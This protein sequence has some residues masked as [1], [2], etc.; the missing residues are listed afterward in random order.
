MRGGR[1]REAG[2]EPL[3]QK[4]FKSVL[5]R[6]SAL[7]TLT[8][9][10]L[11]AC[12]VRCRGDQRCHLD[13]SCCLTSTRVTSWALMFTPARA[14]DPAVHQQNQLG[15]FWFTPS[16]SCPLPPAGWDHQRRSRLLGGRAAASPLPAQSSRQS[17]GR[18]GKAKHPEANSLSKGKDQGK[19]SL[20]LAASSSVP[21][22]IAGKQIDVWSG[23]VGFSFMPQLHYG[24]QSQCPS[25][26]WSDR[27]EEKSFSH[28]SPSTKAGTSLGLAGLTALLAVRWRRSA[29]LH[30]ES[31]INPRR[32]EHL[33]AAA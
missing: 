11:P 9:N 16:L 6:C 28:G 31:W 14:A 30:F 25:H 4:Q 33:I 7:V 26:A 17:M 5:Y 20:A 1:Q 15:P 2:A 18:G 23:P 22:W 13:F 12:A 3:L 19:A 32:P 24:Y 8:W 10:I 21:M 27:A 29:S